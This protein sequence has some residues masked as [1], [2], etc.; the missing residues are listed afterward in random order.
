[1]SGEGPRPSASDMDALLAECVRVVVAAWVESWRAALRR[2][3]RAMQG[4]WPGTKAEARSRVFACLGQELARRGLPFPSHEELARI[5]REV[6]AS[7][8][9]T[10][11]AEA[12]S[13]D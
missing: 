11:L 2:E 8:R 5:S 3:G 12:E 13:G 10:W 6:Y 4:G 7:A 9:R 1:M